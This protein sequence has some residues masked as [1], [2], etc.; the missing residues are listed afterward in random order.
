MKITSK[1]IMVFV[2]LSALF[3]VAPSIV[4]GNVFAQNYPGNDDTSSSSSNDDTSSSSSNDDTS[5]S[6]SNEVE[7]TSPDDGDTVPTG[8][9]TIEGTSSDDGASDCHVYADWNDVSP[10]Q[11]VEATGDDGSDDYSTWEFTY[12]GDYETITEGNTNELTAK[13][14]CGDNA[15]VSNS[16]YDTINVIGEADGSSSSSSDDDE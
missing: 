7:I 12:T 6:S 3:M 9:L 8:E 15:D 4:S 1:T 11:L 10:Y 16:V 13:F 2:V 14:Y 5:S